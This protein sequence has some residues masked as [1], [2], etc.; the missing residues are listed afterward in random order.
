ML[1]QKYANK[2]ALIVSNLGDDVEIM[3]LHTVNNDPLV[4]PA[5]HFPHRDAWLLSLGFKFKL[6]EGG[7]EASFFKLEATCVVP[8]EDVVLVCQWIVPYKPQKPED[9]EALEWVRADITVRGV[10]LL[11]VSRQLV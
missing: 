6:D 4:P 9:T 5:E 7:H 3:W 10:C 8:R 1:R 2:H 11:L